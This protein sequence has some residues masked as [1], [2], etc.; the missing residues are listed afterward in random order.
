MTTILGQ[1]PVWIQPPAGHGSGL[2]FP[3]RRRCKCRSGH[4][5]VIHQTQVGSQPDQRPPGAA[6]KAVVGAFAVAEVI[7]PPLGWLTTKGA[8]GVIPAPTVG[9]A[10]KGGVYLRKEL[11]RHIH[12]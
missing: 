11:F 10:Q 5:G 9:P 4:V 1:Q 7:L 12:A 2:L 3:G 8:V 6:N